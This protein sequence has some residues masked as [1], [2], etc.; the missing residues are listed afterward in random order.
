[1]ISSQDHI[2]CVNAWM[3]RVAKGLAPEPL[4]N[5]FEEAFGALW[6]RAHQT[7]GDV[8]LTAIVDR[9]LSNGA[10]RFP[11]LSELKTDANGL[12][13]KELRK[14]AERAAPNELAD[15]IRFV[16]VEF[17]TV[18]GN[19]TAEILTTPLHA[20]LLRFSIR[21]PEPTDKRSAGKPRSRARKPRKDA[22]S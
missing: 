6:L 17:L 3:E 13:L 20:E 8:T 16:L 5:A 18:L 22:K 19:L 2:A 4:V 10:D 14:N 1:M 11:V 21:R 9:V 12:I 7:L 15:A